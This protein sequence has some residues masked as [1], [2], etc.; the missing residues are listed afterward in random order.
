[1]KQ[2]C[3]HDLEQFTNSLKD[4]YLP[5][6]EGEISGSISLYTNQEK[7]ELSIDD[8]WNDYHSLMFHFCPY[9]GSKQ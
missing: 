3:C 8:G 7:M 5:I 9:C 6:G 4:A 2:F 1:M